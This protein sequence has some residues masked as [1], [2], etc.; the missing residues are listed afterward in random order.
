MDQSEKD[1][2]QWPRAAASAAIFHHGRVLLAQ[3]SKPPLKG[4]WSLPGGHIE[5]GEKAREAAHRELLE[6]IRFGLAK[7]YLGNTNLPMEEISVLLG[8]TESGNFS[9]AF[10][11]WS[12]ESPS[13]WRGGSLQ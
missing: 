3:R 11:R 7:E 10:R 5:P 6:E 2:H 4:I 12:G 13:V 9:H 8:Y 1:R